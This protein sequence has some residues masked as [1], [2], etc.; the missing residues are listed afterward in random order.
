MFV[1]APVTSFLLYD[2][3]YTERYMGLPSENAA[4]YNN[5]V[6]SG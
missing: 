3:I 4:G 6:I 5:N 2:S 1:V